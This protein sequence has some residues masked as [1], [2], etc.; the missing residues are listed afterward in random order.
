MENK[1]NNNYILGII[2]GIIGGFIAAIPW[3][4]AYVYMDMLLSLLALLIALGVLKGYQLLKGKMTKKVPIFIIVISLLV[5]IVTTLVII[6]ALLINQE[7]VPVTIDSFKLLYGYKPFADAIMRDLL[8]SIIFTVLGIS[9]T[10][11]NL[12][13]S[14]Q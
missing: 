1:E 14:I 3:I 11:A 9:G 12:R 10:V 4:I 13:R 6:P 5:V 7:G 8:I 2:G